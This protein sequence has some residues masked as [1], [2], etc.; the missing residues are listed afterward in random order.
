VADGPHY[1]I[2]HI[3]S[4][5]LQKE[6][7]KKISPGVSGW[8]THRK[9]ASLDLSGTTHRHEGEQRLRELEEVAGGTERR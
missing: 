7:W 2:S 9:Y 8:T 1:R 3:A 6:I 4:N 5:Y